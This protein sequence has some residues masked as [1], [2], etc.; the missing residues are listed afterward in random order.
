MLQVRRTRTETQRQVNVGRNVHTAKAFVRPTNRGALW[1]CALSGSPHS[2]SSAGGRAH[3]PSAPG[4]MMTALL[5]LAIVATAAAGEVPLP[6]P[7]N[8]QDLPIAADSITYL[9]GT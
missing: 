8:L 3:L 9:D 1:V 4:L 7:D 5:N 2:L 6:T